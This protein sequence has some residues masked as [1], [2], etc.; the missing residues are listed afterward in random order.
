MFV[1]QMCPE[2]SIQI[3][4]MKVN[5]VET[6]FEQARLAANTGLQEGFV[7]LAGSRRRMTCS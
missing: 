5:S 3:D 7:T 6:A 2:L 1:Q 4:V